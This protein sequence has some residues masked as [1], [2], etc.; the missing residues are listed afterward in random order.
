MLVLLI[1]VFSC[2]SIKFHVIGIVLVIVDN[3]I[4]M[5]IVKGCHPEK[6]TI[7][8][9]KPNLIWCCSE[10]KIYSVYQ[11]VSFVLGKKDVKNSKKASI[12]NA[13]HLSVTNRCI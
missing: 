7:P 2:G 11:F 12:S 8:L 6:N 4:Y 13:T 1:M 3:E 9:N 10:C 5:H